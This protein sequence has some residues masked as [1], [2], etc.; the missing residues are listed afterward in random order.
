MERIVIK[1]TGRI[2][3]KKCITQSYQLV[4]WG[5]EFNITIPE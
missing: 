5:K 3:F 1:E 4:S 2:E